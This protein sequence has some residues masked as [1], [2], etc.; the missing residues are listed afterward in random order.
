[1]SD[2]AI[3]PRDMVDMGVDTP[4]GHMRGIV[5]AFRDTPPIVKAA[6]GLVLAAVLLSSCEV[7]GGPDSR[8]PIIP[9]HGLEGPRH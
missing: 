4:T 7:G 8:R 1:M 3:G 5:D 6:A 2:F 9:T